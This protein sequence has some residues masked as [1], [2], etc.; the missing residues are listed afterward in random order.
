M[1][2][3]ALFLTITLLGLRISA[4]TVIEVIHPEIADIILYEVKDSSLADII[5][6]KTH[7]KKYAN[8]WALRWKFKNW[9]FAN[10][11]IYITDSIECEDMLNTETGER[12]P[13]NGKVYFTTNCEE[14]R[15]R[16]P[17]FHI[18]GMMKVNKRKYIRKQ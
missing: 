10:F 9:G 8:D 16:N 1:K 3:L 17:N 6:Y 11:A 4:Q 14:A 12:Y 5:V 18:D 13:I 7:L 15:Y 2:P